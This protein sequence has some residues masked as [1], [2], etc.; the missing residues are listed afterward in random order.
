[1]NDLELTLQEYVTTANDPKA[2]G[3]WD[4]INSKFPEL[5]DF[6]PILL[7]E[8]VK[9]A[10]DPK[11]NGNWDL[12]NSKFP[13]FG[14]GETTDVTE[15]V[16]EDDSLELPQATM[17]DVDVSERQ[18]INRLNKMQHNEITNHKRMHLTWQQS[19]RL[20]L[21]IKLRL[22]RPCLNKLFPR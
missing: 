15:P 2:N 4:L 9:T 21:N 6:D 5:A 3:D 7:Q 17:E 1:M 19:S 11:A 22:I 8:Y 10:N 20:F 12:I 16:S 13:E 14:L 18:A